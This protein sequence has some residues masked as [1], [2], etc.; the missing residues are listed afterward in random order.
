[1]KAYVPL[2]GFVFLICASENSS[3]AAIGTGEVSKIGG[4]VTGVP[5]IYFGLTPEPTERAEC[6]SNAKGYQFVLDPS[7][8]AGKAL[9]SAILAAKTTGKKITVRGTGA[10]GLGHAM[11]TVSYWILVD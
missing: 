8:D 7:T 1:M 6:N 10:C 3:A 9:Y 5:S 2:I 11:E 4:Q